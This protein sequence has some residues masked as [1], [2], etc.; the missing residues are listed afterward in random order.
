MSTT[1]DCKYCEMSF[2]TDNGL[3]THTLRH[4]A[5]EDGASDEPQV[6]RKPTTYEEAKA[7]VGTP[8]APVEPVEPMAEPIEVEG[9][10]QLSSWSFSGADN[11]EVV[12]LQILEDG[13]FDV[14]ISPDITLTNA[15]KEFW[16]IVRDVY[17]PLPEQM[18]GLQD[19]LN[20]TQAELDLMQE[21]L[22]QRDIVIAGI[23]ELVALL[24]P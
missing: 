6:K 12:R 9:G 21:D 16:R 5:D 19:R 23:R 17:P 8:A 13:T 20:A 22:K 24:K 4:H 10:D 2:I 11:V 7:A 15:A 3:Q 18:Q 14:T 1:F